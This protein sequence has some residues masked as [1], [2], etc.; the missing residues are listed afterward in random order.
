MK[1]EIGKRVRLLAPMVNESSKWMP[2]EDG[3]PAGLEGTI[4][5]VSMDGDR[6][7]HQVGVRWDNGRS[8]NLM[9]YA[10]HFMVF[11]EAKSEGGAR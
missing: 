5:C 6:E 2:V 4:V 8:L 10:D 9:P 3:M 1:P 7:W 11:E